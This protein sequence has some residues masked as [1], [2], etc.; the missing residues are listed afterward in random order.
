M[1]D[2]ASSIALR[3]AMEE[4]KYRQSVQSKREEM[5][6]SMYPGFSWKPALPENKEAIPGGPDPWPRS[7]RTFELPQMTLVGYP[8]TWE[9]GL[10]R[11]LSAAQCRRAQSMRQGITGRPASSAGRP[12]VFIAPPRVPSRGGASAATEGRPNS[13]RT[14]RPKSART[15]TSRILVQGEP[16]PRPQSSC[17]ASALPKSGPPSMVSI[18][19]ARGPASSVGSMRGPPSMVSSARG[20]PSPAGSTIRSSVPSSSIL[21]TKM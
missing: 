17:G 9:S 19:S 3:Q 21:E 20:P 13:A 5:L 2:L 15:S 16:P 4:Q 1:V 8:T 6:K 12:G 7:L 14:D 11:P 18:G 10:G